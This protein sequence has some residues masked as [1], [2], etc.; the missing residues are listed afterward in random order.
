MVRALSILP[1][2]LALFGASY[3]IMFMRTCLHDVVTVTRLSS[4]RRTDELTYW[5]ASISSVAC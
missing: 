4:A 2:N 3:R 1:F 5:P